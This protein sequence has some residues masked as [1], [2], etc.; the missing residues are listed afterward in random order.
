MRITTHAMSPLGIP[1]SICCM[2][3]NPAFLLTC[4]LD[5]FEEGEG[6]TH[7]GFADQWARGM[8][9]T[10]QIANERSRQ[11][12]TQGKAQYD[13]KVK[14]VVLKPGGRVLFRNLR[15]HGD[16]GKLRS[17]LEKTIYVVKEHVT[18]N[19]YVVLYLVVTV[20]SKP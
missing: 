16:Q 4:F 14:D 18:V 2:D 12:S 15:K 19:Q 6:V 8:T 3:T 5:L 10:Y 1:H 13:V 17:Y 9:E 20:R 11:A 7:K